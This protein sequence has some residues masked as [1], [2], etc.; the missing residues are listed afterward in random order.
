MDDF[1]IRFYWEIKESRGKTFNDNI[2]Q[3]NSGKA[4]H[5]DNAFK[6]VALIPWNFCLS[7]LMTVLHLE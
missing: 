1:V 4:A 2:Q 5:N 6:S 3:K 7:D